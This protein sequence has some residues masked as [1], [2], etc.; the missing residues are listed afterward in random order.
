MSETNE[1]NYVNNKCYCCLTT[2]G[3]FCTCVGFFGFPQYPLYYLTGNACCPTI[4]GC[5]IFPCG[6]MSGICSSMWCGAI[7][8]CSYC[9]R[10]DWYADITT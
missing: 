3:L 9:P 8:G 4:K 7:S 1:N 10:F 2:F 6:G 5:I